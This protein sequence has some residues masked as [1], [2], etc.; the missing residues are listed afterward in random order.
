[1]NNYTQNDVLRLA[2]RINNSKRSYLLV[3]PLQAKHLAVSPKAALDMMGCLGER[4][5]AAYPGTRLVIGFAETATAIGAAAAACF[6]DDCIYVQ[7]TR[8]DIAEVEEWIIF[9]EEHSHAVEQKLCGAQFGEWLSRTETVIFIDDELSTGKTLINMAEQLRGRYPALRNVRMV[10]ASIMNRL[11]PENEARLQAAGMDSLCL[12]KLME[13][14][15]TARVAGYSVEAAREPVSG[16]AARWVRPEQDAPL[17]NPRL[18]VSAGAYRRHCADRAQ[19][20]LAGL[21]AGLEPGDR[22]LVL[23]TEEC[24]YPALALGAAIEEVHDGPVRCHATTRSPIGVSRDE[25]Y[26]IREGYHIRSFYAAGRNTYIYNPGDYDLIA[27]VTDS[28]ADCTQALDELAAA[29]AGH[30][31]GK[32]YCFGGR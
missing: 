8:E 24:M 20:M 32:L 11:T 31:C 6:G 10:A 15:Y 13:E 17:M 18:G 30:A 29:F 21:R 5:A 12:V 22:V 28:P 26:P 27:V 25:G 2:K 4:L 1:M 9:E 16:S 23:G 3:N 19:A 14:D 7:T